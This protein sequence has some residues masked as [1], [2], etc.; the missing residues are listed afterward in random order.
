[1]RDVGIGSKWQL[2]SRNL[3]RSLETLSVV[4]QVKDE[5]LGGVTGG[6]R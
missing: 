5:R 4:A 1:M 2:V 3:K 6:E